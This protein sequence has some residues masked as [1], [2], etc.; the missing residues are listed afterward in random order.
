MPERLNDSEI[1]DITKSLE[2]GLPIDD[3]YRY[4]IFKEARQVELVWTGKNKTVK[5]VALP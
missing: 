1:R 2:A 3:K 5:D 4:L